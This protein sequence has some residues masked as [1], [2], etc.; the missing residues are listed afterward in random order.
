MHVGRVMVFTYSHESSPL[1]GSNNEMENIY[2]FFGINYD[3][4]LLSHVLNS[5]TNLQHHCAIFHD[6]YN[7]SRSTQKIYL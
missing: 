7:N 2:E 1:H 3:K 5:S 6:A 4:Y